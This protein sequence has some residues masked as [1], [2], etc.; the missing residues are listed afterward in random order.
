MAL[1]GL[2]SAALFCAATA[3]AETVGAVEHFPTKCKVGTLVGGPD[4][5]VWF[6]CFREGPRPGAAGRSFLGRITPGGQ[7]SEF[8]VPAHFGIGGLVA[9]PDGSLWVTL[10]GAAYPPSKSR[11]SAIGRVAPDGTMAL[12]R[13]GLRERSAPGEIVAAPDGALWFTDTASG[14][15]PEIGRITPQGTIVELPVG[16]KAPLGLGGIVA[17]P[18]GSAWFTQVFDLPHGDG[19]PGG[20]VGRVGADGSLISYGAAPA[21]L[22]APLAA[23]DGNIWFVDAAGPAAIDRVTP[24]GEI[25]RFGS[26]TLGVPS[27]LVGG[28]D[29]NVWFTAQQSVGRVTPGGEITTFTDCMD[30]RQRFSEATSIVAGPG[31]DLWFTSVTSRQLPAMGEPPTVGRVTPDGQITQFKAGIESEPHS[32]LA[33]PDGRVWF[34]GGG[35]EIERITPPTAPVNT[36]IFGRGEARAGGPARLPVEVPGPGKVE[37]RPLGMLLPGGRTVRLSGSSPVSVAAPTCGTPSVAFRL[38]GEAATRIRQQRQV[39][40]KV[41]VTFTP[42]GGSPNTEVRT[43]VLRK[44]PHRH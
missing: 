19:E 8:A 44:P 20:L 26:K 36:F 2:A 7:V 29:G 22:G 21:A 6:S 39:K 16:L 41:S 31:D 11:P 1:A 10:S 34:A 15:P 33:G 25:S 18:D 3:S 24:S 43:I 13:T 12:F 9:G 42:T 27:D 30:Y 23:P 4:G 32:I 38:R 35:E 28:P 37:L 17:A 5:N 40:I 14:Q